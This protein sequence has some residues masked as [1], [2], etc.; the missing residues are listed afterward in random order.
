[1]KFFY[2]HTPLF[3]IFF[4]KKVKKTAFLKAFCLKKCKI[5]I[6]IAFFYGKILLVAFST[7]KE[8]A[9]FAVK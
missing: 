4:R 2:A 3:A 6:D 5:G 9:A 8:I 7:K 1:M